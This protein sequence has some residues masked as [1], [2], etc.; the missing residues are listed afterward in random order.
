[1]NKNNYTI[2]K[3]VS[4]CCEAKIVWYGGRSYRSNIH[5]VCVDCGSEVTSENV[6]TLV[7]MTHKNIMKGVWRPMD[8][9][10]LV[11]DM[12]FGCL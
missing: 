3:K 8:E 2:V 9:P 6:K 10:V 11:T 5:Y 4:E 1:M 7:Y 12:F